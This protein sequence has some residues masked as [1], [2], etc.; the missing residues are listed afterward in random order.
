MYN[1]HYSVPLSFYGTFTLSVE[2]VIEVSF[3]KL[4]IIRGGVF[5][6]NRVIP[7]CEF[8]LI[9]RQIDHIQASIH[10]L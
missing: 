1:H 7:F 3:R 8:C 5:L 6:Q 9:Q 2:R 10:I 4:I